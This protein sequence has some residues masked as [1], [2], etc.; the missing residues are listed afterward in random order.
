VAAEDYR[1]LSFD[2]WQRMAEGW[3]RDRRWIWD[4][5]RAVSEWMLEA[6]DPQAGETILELAAGTGETGF[7]AASA[8]GE[9]GRLISTDFA[10]K[11]VE[12]ARSESERLGLTNVDHRQLDAQ[13]MDLEDDSVDGVLCRWGY[14]LTADPQAA[15]RET[16]RVLRDGGKLALSVWGAPQDNPWA[17]IPSRL[18]Q[19][20][21]GASPPDPTAPGI[22]AM[23][24]PDRTRS[25]LDGAGFE[26]RRMENVGMT[27]RLDDLDAYW[28]FLTRQVGMLAVT[29]AALAEGDQRALRGRLQEAVEPYRT[30]GG[31]ALPGVTQNTLAT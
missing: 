28:S 5:S 30:N 13:E 8:L 18:L 19:E 4:S 17:S 29:I 2:V 25:L 27:W 31:Y 24:D 14:M 20:Q 16:R 3:D 9:R 22:F 15:L 26:V 1:E 12:A 23:A 6:L 21:T 10:P 7:A 11:M